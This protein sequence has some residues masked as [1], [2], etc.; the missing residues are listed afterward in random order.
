M[1]TDDDLKV[2]VTDY[3]VGEINPKI[4]DTEQYIVLTVTRA[5]KNYR[6][7]FS[8]TL[9]SKKVESIELTNPRYK[10][11]EGETELDLE[12]LKVQA[13]Y[14]NAPSE[15]VDDYIVLAE[16]FNPTL[17]NVEQNITVTY[18]HEGLTAFATFPVIVYGIPVVSVDTNGYNGEWTP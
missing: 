10:Y 11:L 18:T 13:N 3:T 1:Y 17:Y 5:G 8:I 14:S 6:G 15:F 2:E 4:L 16:E 12:G 7:V 9:E